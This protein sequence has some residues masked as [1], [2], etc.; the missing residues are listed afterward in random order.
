MDEP[1]LGPNPFDPLPARIGKSYEREDAPIPGLVSSQPGYYSLP[2]IRNCDD[3]VRLVRRLIDHL[4]P[5]LVG[6]I[7]GD[8]K[9]QMLFA[10]QYDRSLDDVRRFDA[11]A[12]AYAGVIGK[13]ANRL[14]LAL[15]LCLHLRVHMNRPDVQ[16]FLQTNNVT[17]HG[18]TPLAVLV[19]KPLY[20]ARELL[21]PFMQI[22]LETR[23]GTSD[24]GLGS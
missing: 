21:A 13:Q 24:I 16:M 2:K 19:S 18:A 9:Q 17:L 15:E 11:T 20:R 7:G 5:V 10:E 6:A 4:G 22:Q 23:I 8:E 12:W 1:R 14:L 3:G